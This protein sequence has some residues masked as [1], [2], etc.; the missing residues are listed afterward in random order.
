MIPPICK[1]PSTSS[2][3]TSKDNI[4]DNEIPVPELHNLDSMSLHVLSNNINTDDKN[5]PKND[6]TSSDF[7]TQIQNF[8]NNIVNS[9]EV[10]KSPPP[11][12]STDNKNNNKNKN[13][14]GESLQLPNCGDPLTLSDKVGNFPS[15]DMG[16]NLPS[17]NIE[18]D[19]ELDSFLPSNFGTTKMQLDGN[20]NFMEGLDEEN[21][22]DSTTTTTNDNNDTTTTTDNNN[23]NGP[24][25][26]GAEKGGGGGGASGGKTNNTT[27]RAKTAKKTTRKTPYDPASCNTNKNMASSSS[28]SASSS[29]GGPVTT[30][31]VISSKGSNPDCDLYYKKRTNYEFCQWL[32]KVTSSE[33][34]EGSKLFSNENIPNCQK[35]FLKMLAQ[36]SN[37]YGVDKR[38]RDSLI[39]GVE[40]YSENDLINV[41]KRKITIYEDISSESVSFHSL[42]S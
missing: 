9:S 8:Y 19:E 40:S 38:I 7:L 20:M 11:T 32:R 13:N 36:H 2:T 25:K 16:S 12:T 14:S 24:K 22:M 15:K 1:S 34:E 28:S 4:G 39:P 27:K 26:K 5:N 21:L 41:T 30:T 29:T 35:L 17:F 31:T 42:I 33:S 6:S 23:K 3:D 10:K 37:N 18:F